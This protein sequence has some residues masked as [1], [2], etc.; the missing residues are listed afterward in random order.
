MLWKIWFILIGSTHCAE[1]PGHFSRSTYSP[2]FARF[3]TI[4]SIHADVQFLVLPLAVS[5]ISL[6]F[7]GSI[8]QRIAFLFIASY[9]RVRGMSAH[10]LERK[11]K[12]KSTVVYY[13]KTC[14]NMNGLSWFSEKISSTRLIRWRQYILWS[15]CEL[16]ILF[17]RIC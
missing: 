11:I 14:K 6:N 17:G 7:N 5:C 1:M 16:V 10:K 12:P 9:R 2:T 8:F 4:N 15:H 13:R 3:F